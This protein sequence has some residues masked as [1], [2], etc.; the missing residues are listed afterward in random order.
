MRLFDWGPSP[1]CM[2][3]RAILEY[4][5]IEYERVMVLG[6]PLYELWRR[7]KIGKVPALDLDGTLI[8]DSTDIAHELERRYPQPAILPA[9]ARE[10]GL[11]HALEEWA[12]ESLYWIGIYYQ[13]LDPE[14]APLTPRAFQKV[15]VLGR[16]A[17]EIYLRRVSRQLRQQ[18]T[19]RKPPQHIASDLERHLD[20]AEGLL[21]RRDY[22]LDGGPFLCDFALLAQLH[23]LRRTPVG[24]RTLAKRDAIERYLE[25]MKR[26]R[27]AA[28][29]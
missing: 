29:T 8:C 5:K 12:D 9:S 2:K 28:P 21:E 14:G 13:W 15:P 3:V 19:G 11:C 24:G 25:R 7:G 23:Y 4:K 27:N 20:A 1:F 10:R 17:Y 6:A 16:A 22:L 18:G 26:H